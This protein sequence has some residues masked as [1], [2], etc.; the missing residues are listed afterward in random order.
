MQ[1][2]QMWAA[3]LWVVCPRKF[4]ST[5]ITVPL[6]KKNYWTSTLW[7]NA[8]I[9]AS[10]PDFVETMCAK[11]GTVIF[12]LDNTRWLNADIDSTLVT[13]PGFLCFRTDR[14]CKSNKRGGGTAIFID[15]RWCSSPKQSFTYVRDN[16]EATAVTRRTKLSCKFLSF[17]ICSIYIPRRH[18]RHS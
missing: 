17:I 10:C 8:R 11:K 6:T 15:Q 14:A 5:S 16:I 12:W 7:Q 9:A 1:C 3:Y 13:P 18:A 2:Y 4:L